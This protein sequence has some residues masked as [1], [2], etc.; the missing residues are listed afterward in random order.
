MI[1]RGVG[2]LRFSVLLIRASLRLV[3]GAARGARARCAVRADQTAAEGR[4]RHA[5]ETARAREASHA[6]IEAYISPKSP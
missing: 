6:A 2:I 3:F 4:L 5:E 1:I